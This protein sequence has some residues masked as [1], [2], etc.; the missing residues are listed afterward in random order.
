LFANFDTPS[1]LDAPVSKYKRDGG[2]EFLCGQLVG[3]TQ[4]AGSLPA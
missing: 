4:R 2:V 1:G 3:W